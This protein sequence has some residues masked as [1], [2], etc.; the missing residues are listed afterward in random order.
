MNFRSATWNALGTIDL[1]IEHPI[2]GWVP[3]TASP[4]DPELAGKQI[5]A[6]ASKGTVAPYVPPPPIVIDLSALDMA[7]LNAALTEP[8]SVVRALGLVMFAEVNKLRVK[9][10][11]PAYTMP[12][13][14][15]ALKAQMR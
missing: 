2:F 10:G 9:N 1:E 14:V 4:N 8:G 5:Y 6:E 3:F 11:D 7:A 13:F 12:Q 15:T